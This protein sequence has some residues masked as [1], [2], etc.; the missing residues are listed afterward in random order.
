MKEAL[1]RLG[2]IKEK[3]FFASGEYDAMEGSS[4]LA[5]L[6]PWNQF[7]N[8]DLTKTK[9]L[10]ALPYFFDFRNIY[11]RSEVEAAGLRYFA[12]GK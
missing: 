2:S 11:N 12:V 9:K 3:V 8:L 1:W 7:R 5:I 10:L 4:A 6:T